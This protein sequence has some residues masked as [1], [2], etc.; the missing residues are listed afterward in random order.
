MV[1]QN[2]QQKGSAV[3]TKKTPAEVEALEIGTVD[4]EVEYK[5][6]TFEFKDV[7]SSIDDASI[8][9]GELFEKN[10]IISAF[11]EII[12]YQ[13]KNKLI[14]AGVTNRELLEIFYPAW[15]EAAGLGK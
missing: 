15:E 1:C 8:R 2:T 12:G 7:P 9:V 3:A 4:F 5:G 11:T 13:M 10:Q 6:K 14:L